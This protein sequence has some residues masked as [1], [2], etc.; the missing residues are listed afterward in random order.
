MTPASVNC[1]TL[2]R[3]VICCALSL[4]PLKAG[5][6][7]DARMAMM[8]MTTNSSSRVNAEFPGGVLSRDFIAGSACLL[9]SD[10]EVNWGIYPTSAGVLLLRPAGVQPV[11]PRGVLI[12][13]WFGA[14]TR[15]SFSAHGL[16]S[17]KEMGNGLGVWE[18][19]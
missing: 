9:P 18:E 13:G 17:G 2:F 6:N 11:E 4:A 15:I 14:L 10:F 5:N 1:L 16:P 7:S 12:R 8:A 3:D 19:S